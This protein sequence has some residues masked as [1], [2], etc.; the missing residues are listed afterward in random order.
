MN[1]SR[2]PSLSSASSLLSS[3]S[4]DGS[5]DDLD[6]TASSTITSSS[7][8]DSDSVSL[9]NSKGNDKCNLDSKI[10]ETSD[11]KLA[12]F[13]LMYTY[14]CDQTK[15]NITEREMILKFIKRILP[16]DNI[17]PNSYYKLNKHM[18]LEK[19]KSLKLCPFCFDELNSNECA[20]SNCVKNQNKLIYKLKPVELMKFDVESQLN[21]IIKK[22]WS[23]LSMHIKI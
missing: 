17:I 18:D 20:N 2:S 22:Q 16:P 21:H 7:E 14:I 5:F 23:Y 4:L 8:M 12:E 6:E 9:N 13:N 10:Y 15:L 3:S 19:S 1:M 11:L